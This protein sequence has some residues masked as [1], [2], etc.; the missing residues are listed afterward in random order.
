[1]TAKK[2]KTAKGKIQIKSD[3]TA[4]GTKVLLLQADG[5]TVDLTH[6]LKIRSIAWFVDTGGPSTVTLECRAEMLEADVMLA[7]AQFCEPSNP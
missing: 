3:G 4:K 5:V 1:M 6:V 2:P 7:R